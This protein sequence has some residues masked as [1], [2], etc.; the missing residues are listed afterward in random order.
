MSLDLGPYNGLMTERNRKHPHIKSYQYNSGTFYCVSYQLQGHQVRKRGFASFEEAEFF[1]FESRKMIRDG[2]WIKASVNLMSKM[3]LDTLYERYCSK[4]G[5]KRSLASIK[6]GLGAWKNHISPLLGNKKASD[7]GKQTLAL[8]VDAL[9]E[10]GLTDNSIKIPR[11]ELSNVLKMAFDYD[12]IQMLP[13]FPK[14]KSRP[15]KKSIYSPN[16]IQKILRG[17]DNPQYRLMAFVQY[18]LALRV[19]ELLAL[20]VGCFNEEDST[21]LIDKQVDRNSR[22]KNW[23]KRLGPTKNRIVRR[24]PVS[25]ELLELIQPYLEARDKRSPLWISSY[26]HPVSDSA[27]KAALKRGFDSAELEGSFSSHCLR[28]S[29]LD[30]LVNYSGL[31]IQAVAWLG[32]HSAKVLVSRYS[33]PNIE[34]IVATMTQKLKPTNVLSCNLAASLTLEK[35]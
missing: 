22:D 1:Y 32:R 30:F 13:A 9:R 2:S 29:M 15:K 14:L 3:N 28:A 35:P 34:Q 24:L 4:I 5:H 26:L 20:R 18:Q 11:A 6:N 21:V 7:I 23:F 25:Q 12:L 16:E 31:N 10:K 27:Y 8:W 33:K 17:I 19:G